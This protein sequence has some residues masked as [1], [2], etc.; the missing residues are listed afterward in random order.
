MPNV[1][2]AGD[3]SQ[4]RRGGVSIATAA[5]VYFRAESTV[6]DWLNNLDMALKAELL[7]FELS[8]AVWWISCLE[9]FLMWHMFWIWT[10][11]VSDLSGLWIHVTHI[12]RGICGI[13]MVIKLPNTHDILSLPENPQNSG[14][15]FSVTEMVPILMS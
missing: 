11:H 5:K 9:L 1:E 15:K 3:Q 7:V 2:P 14:Q 12:F 13:F 10:T 4:Q 6:K 8:S